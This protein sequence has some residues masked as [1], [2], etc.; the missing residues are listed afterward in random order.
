MGP[1]SL[2]TPLPSVIDSLPT[3]PG[4]YYALGDRLGMSGGFSSLG[5]PHMA[6]K[7]GTVSYPLT[8]KTHI[9]G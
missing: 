9:P 5:I 8:S 2:K 3:N 7:T 4:T 6:E 1:S